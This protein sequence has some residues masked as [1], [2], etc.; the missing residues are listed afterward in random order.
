MAIVTEKYTTT[1]G[2]V[3]NKTYSDQGKFIQNGNGDKYVE[4]IDPLDVAVT[5]TETTEDIPEKELTPEEALA[6]LEEV[7]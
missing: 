6:M 5:Y 4:A 1:S 3:L 7:I 2:V